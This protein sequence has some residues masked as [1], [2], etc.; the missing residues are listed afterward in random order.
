[1]EMDYFFIK[2]HETVII[3]ARWKHYSFSVVRRPAYIKDSSCILYYY[4]HDFVNVRFILINNEIV[5]LQN[6]KLLGNKTTRSLF[7][8]NELIKICSACNSVMLDASRLCIKI[9]TNSQLKL[10]LKYY[11]NKLFAG[12]RKCTIRFQ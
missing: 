12:I 1:M 9:D 10:M 7:K 6:T 8:S 5:R 4:G 11:Q 2:S 3:Q